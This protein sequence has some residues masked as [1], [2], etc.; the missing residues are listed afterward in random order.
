MPLFPVF[1]IIALVFQIILAVWLVEMSIIAWI[2]APSWIIIGIFIY[3]FYS[4]K[5]A[6]P[7]EDELLV[8]EEEQAPPGNEYRVMVPVA[9]PEN[10]LSLVLNTI[11][12]CSHRKAR[13]KLLHMVKVFDVV[14]LR[15]AGDHLLE[16]RE[17]IVEAMIYLRPRFPITST[18]RY[19]R[20]IARGIISTVREKKVNLIIMGW[21]GEKKDNH[22]KF[23]STLDPVINQSPCDIIILKNCGN[24]KFNHLM[25]PVLKNDNDA[26]ALETAKKIIEKKDSTILIHSPCNPKEQESR[27][28]YIESLIKRFKDTSVPINVKVE[29]T[30]DI[31]NSILK[32]AEK[33]DAVVLGFSPQHLLHSVGIHNIFEEVAY[34]CKK[35]LILVKAARG[36]ADWTKKWI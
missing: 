24:R 2:I 8:I 1:P 35:P 36:I 18:I 4:K 11:K 12:L 17:G 6:L 5:H 26:Y 28:K 20:N 9:N 13:I 34:K 19:C 22:F 16:G 7:I 31:S 15:D 29:A 33:S 10:A 32:E 25:V 30:L 14:S 27:E 21:H 3:Q 23:G